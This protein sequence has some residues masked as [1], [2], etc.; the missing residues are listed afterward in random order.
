[1][2]KLTSILLTIGMLF[3]TQTVSANPAQSYQSGIQLAIQRILENLNHPGITRGAVIAS[4][5]QHEP[6]Y[7][8]HWTRDAGL[9]MLTLLSQMDRH[10]QVRT[11]IQNWGRFEKFTQQQA[12]KTP[13][14][15]LGEPKFMVNGQPFT[16]PWGRPQ[17][18]GPAI[19]TMAMLLAFRNI[20]TYVEA[21]IN[22]LLQN[23][24]QPNFDLWEE[25]KGH[26][27]FTLYAQMMSLR[28]AAIHYEAQMR[29]QN[30][31]VLHR[32]SMKI[33]T[34]LQKFIDR[35]RNLIV[36]TLAGSEGIA[37]PAGLDISIILA[38]NYFGPS[39]R[40]SSG[41]QVFWS[42]TQ[43]FILN[44]AKQLTDTF[45]RLYDINKRFTN[46]AP[47]IGRYPEDVYDGNG[48]S[49]GHPWYLA[50]FGMAEFNCSVVL[51]NLQRGVINTDP[52]SHAYYSRFTPNGALP[53]SARITPAHEQYWTTLQG[54]INYAESFIQRANFH[55][56]NDGHMSEQFDRSSGYRRGASD[57]TWSYAS[58]IRALSRCETARKELNKAYQR[59][60]G[61]R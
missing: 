3:S 24:Q 39:V 14:S 28:Y 58:K 19:R 59:M 31:I 25:V 18:D 4:P 49:G 6:N 47:A 32:E 22:Y 8:Y 16:G 56:G 44:T 57:L 29:P 30:A 12:M 20:D 48:F 61:R 53:R 35:S 5:S 60:Q 54:L 36:P 21:D 41:S 33:E 42:Y 27:F 9:V 2:K 17:N 45:G 43:P 40:P 13:G 1:M 15:S 50:T 11:P 51:E 46:M 52:M 55:A 7:F 23:W 37:K 34:F 38:M 10:P 26:H